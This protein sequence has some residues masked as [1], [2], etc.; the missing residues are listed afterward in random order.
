MLNAFV[1]ISSAAVFRTSIAGMPLLSVVLS[2]IL[3]ASTAERAYA[4]DVEARVAVL[5]TEV[6]AIEH[7]IE[8]RWGTRFLALEARMQVLDE[9]LAKITAERDAL[10]ETVAASITTAGVTAHSSAGASVRKLQMTS[11]SGSTFVAA[12]AWQV[13]EFP[14]GSNCESPGKAYLKPLMPAEG[15]TSIDDARITSPSAD[16]S[17]MSNVNGQ[18]RTEIQRL[19]APIKIVHDASCVN[20]PRLELPLSTTVQTLTVSGALTAQTLT[21]NSVDIGTAISTLQSTPQSGISL[22]VCTD[23]LQSV[24][25]STVAVLSSCDSN[26]GSVWGSSPCE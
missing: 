4:A 8:Q 21:V 26:G 3:Y 9:A 23:N 5:E 20:P 7:N 14:S 15:M 10:K 25:S 22:V 2:L 17:L 24:V 16:F 13:H 12:K 18:T 19:A 6:A 1:I 11:N